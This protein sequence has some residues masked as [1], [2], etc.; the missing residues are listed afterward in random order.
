MDALPH[1]AAASGLAA[2]ESAA[3]TPKRI[4]AG[5]PADSRTAQLR[6]DVLCRFRSLAKQVIVFAGCSG[7][8]ASADWLIARLGLKHD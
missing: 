3:L 1:G 8:Q 6:G 7:F 5:A 4:G 2:P